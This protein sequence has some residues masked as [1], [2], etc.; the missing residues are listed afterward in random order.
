[1]KDSENKGCVSAAWRKVP[2]GL[3]D[4]QVPH[5][6]R[7][8]EGSQ[9]DTSELDLGGRG[10]GCCAEPEPQKQ[11]KPL[12]VTRQELG[13]RGGGCGGLGKMAG[14]QITEAA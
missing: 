5:A 12:S 3:G 7:A 13:T 2:R 14:K 11:A 9:E 4:M 1:M 8:R 6:G 10:A